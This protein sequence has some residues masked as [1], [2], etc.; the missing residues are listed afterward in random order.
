MHLSCP[1][2]V[3]G[4][5]FERGPAQWFICCLNALRSWI[6]STHFRGVLRHVHCQS[7]SCASHYSDCCIALADCLSLQWI[8]TCRFSSP[9]AISVCERPKP[10]PAVAAEPSTRTVPKLAS[11]YSGSK[12][13]YKRQEVSPQPTSIGSYSG[14][15]YHDVSYSSSTSSYSAFAYHS[16][17][18]GN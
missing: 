14:G 3:V 11:Q 17:D 12:I 1:C 18:N 16:S 4:R 5:H 9:R 2:R 7:S 8:R 10:I 13:P 6:C 15:G